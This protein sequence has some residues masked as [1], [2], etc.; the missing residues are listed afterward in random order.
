MYQF[1]LSP[2]HSW[3]RFFEYFIH[4]SY[5]LDFNAWQV[6]SD[7]HKA[8][9]AQKKKLYSRSLRERLGLIVDKP[10]SGESGTS[11]DGNTARTLFS[12]SAISEEITCIDKT[13]LDRCHHLLQCLSSGYKINTV[14]FKNYAIETARKLVATYPWYNLPSS[15]HKVLIH[16]SEV[17]DYALLSIGELSKEAAESCNKL[18]RQ[19]RRDNT[20]KMSRVVTNTDLMHRHLLNSDP[21]ISSLRKLPKKTKTLLSVEVLNLLSI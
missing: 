4:I 6:R 7:K 9:L 15:V 11:N 3:I 18:V 17:I 21:F 20:R 8:L 1:G 19:F 16:G 14:T 2:L 5:R 12:N 13:L 10:R